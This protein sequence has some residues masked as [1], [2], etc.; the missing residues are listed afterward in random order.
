[1]LGGDKATRLLNP[2]DPASALH[3]VAFSITTPP[4]EKARPGSMIS[5]EAGTAHTIT[6]RAL[7][8]NNIIMRFMRNSFFYGTRIPGVIETAS[9]ESPLPEARPTERVS[10]YVQTAQLFPLDRQSIK[11]NP[12]NVKKM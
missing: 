6:M 5:A 9:Q 3:A 12:P 10:H 2:A 11:G 1:L 8:V 4:S 7:A